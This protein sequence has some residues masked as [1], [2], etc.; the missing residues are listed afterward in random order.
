MKSI[1]IANDENFISVT[2]FIDPN[3]WEENVTEDSIVARAINNR[4]K[5]NIVLLHDAGGIRTE[6]IKALPKII[7]FYQKHGYEFVSISSLMGKSRNSV[8]PLV[9]KKVQILIIYYFF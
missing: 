3:D 1:A 4:D 2:S 9:D 8:M 6:T 7:D 5:G